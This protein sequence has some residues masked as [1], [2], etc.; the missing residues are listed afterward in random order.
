MEPP[1]HWGLQASS[2]GVPQGSGVAGALTLHLARLGPARSRVPKAKPEA[3]V[4]WLRGEP[5]A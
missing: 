3:R 1:C 4:L 2:S 5:L